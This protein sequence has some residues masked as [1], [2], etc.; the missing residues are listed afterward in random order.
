MTSNKEVAPVDHPTSSRWH[1][2][3][4]NEEPIL[5]PL[6]KGFFYPTAKV[7]NLSQV[8]VRKYNFP[9]IFEGDK[10]N[11]E[12]DFYVFDR[13]GNISVD[14]KKRPILEKKPRTSGQPKISLLE[15]NGLSP[16]SHLVAFMK[17]TLCRK[18][19][20]DE[21]KRR[22]NQA[23][24]SIFNDWKNCTN[25]KSSLYGAGEDIYKYWYE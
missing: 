5:L 11:G 2:L 3:Q 21:N 22:R 20:P 7:I 4:T 17:S 25:L 13:R 24:V 10:F 14:K 23:K 8:E 16:S 15:E 12:S 19:T 6:D 9:D 18:P 1:I